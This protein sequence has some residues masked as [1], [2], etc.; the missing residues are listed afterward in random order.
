MLSVAEG[1][2]RLIVLPPVDVRMTTFR[3]NAFDIS[4]SGVAMM[5]TSLGVGTVEGATYEAEAPSPKLVIVPHAEPEHPVPE[6]L[7]EIVGDG[8]ELATGVRDARKFAVAPAS[9]EDGPFAE[10]EK[11]LVRLIAA[12]AAFDGSAPLVAVTATSGGDGRICGAA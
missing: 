12:D 5:V 7:Q 3:G 1:G 9:T 10:N 6:T 2:E 8:L 4:A 11:R